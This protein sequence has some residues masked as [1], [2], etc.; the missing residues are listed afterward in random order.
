MPDNYNWIKMADH[1]LATAIV[2][3]E[4][5]PLQHETIAFHCQQAVEKYIKFVLAANGIEFLRSH[6]L[7][8][9]L[10]LYDEK[11][12]VTNDYFEKTNNL[13]GFAVEIRYPDTIV[14][15]T[16]EQLIDTIDIAFFFRQ[17]AGE[18]FSLPVNN[19]LYQLWQ[20]EKK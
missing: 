10:E 6:D 16:K 12:P 2:V 17:W 15:L 14:N 8:Y 13:K 19:Q 20:Q 3:F 11:T 1:D 4:R 18:L 7:N 5:L 9:L